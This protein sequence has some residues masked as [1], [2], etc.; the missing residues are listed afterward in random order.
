LLGLDGDALTSTLTVAPHLP[1]DWN[2]VQ[3]S[4]YRIGASQVSGAFTRAKGIMRVRLSV[5]GE[6]LRTLFSPALPPGSTLISAEL[7]GKTVTARAT[8]S[9]VDVHAV[10]DAGPAKQ[11]DLVLRFDDGVE[12][13]PDLVAAEPGDRSRAV[14][15]IGTHAEAARVMF[16]LAGPSG[17]TARVPAWH[18]DGW[19]RESG[20]ETVA[21]PASQ[22]DFSHATITYRKP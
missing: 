10:V 6:P 2:E 11:F 9:D 12:L 16:E 1:A 19:Q 14:R 5:D 21:F 15:L 3:F 7:N 13:L 20:D 22:S 17:K 8:A 4:R 18:G